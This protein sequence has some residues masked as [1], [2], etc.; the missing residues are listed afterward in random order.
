[1]FYSCFHGNYDI[2]SLLLAAGAEACLVDKNFCT[3]LHYVSR[4]DDPRMVDLLF[5]YNKSTTKVKFCNTNLK[6]GE[7]DLGKIAKEDAS[8]DE[9]EVIDLKSVGYEDIGD[10]EDLSFTAGTTLTMDSV[11][12][13]IENFKI[14]NGDENEHESAD[15]VERCYLL[16][17]QDKLGR[18][19]L[20]YA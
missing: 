19:A 2:M 14:I 4:N 16:N 7:I 1:M 8:E 13:Q 15:N 11:L 6:P 18:T 17:F 5:L 12:K 9:E 10:D 20:H 3:P